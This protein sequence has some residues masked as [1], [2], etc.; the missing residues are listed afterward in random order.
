[1][2][3]KAVKEHWHILPVYLILLSLGIFLVFKLPQIVLIVPVVLAIPLVLV[4]KDAWKTISKYWVS[5]V[6]IAI[7]LL[8][9]YVRLQD[10]GW[11]YLRNIDSYMFYR[12]MDYIVQNGGIMP[13][14]DPLIL[15][16][17]GGTIR[18]ELFPFQYLGAYT[19]M[20]TRL[21][22][23]DLQLIQYLIYFP[24]LVASLAA[25]PMY[26]IG[27]ML[28]DKKAGILAA[29]FIVLDFTNVSRSLGGDPD[30]DAIVILV[31]LIVMVLFLFTYKYIN[32]HG[33]N[34]K[35]LV[36]S[37]ITGVAMGLWAHT[38]EGYWYVLW[39][40]TAM[41]ALKIV[42][43]ALQHRRIG[44]IIKE[45]R[46]LLTSYIIIIALLLLITYPAYGTGKITDFLGP[47]KFSQLKSEEGI[48]FPN[49]YVSVAELQGGDVKGVIQRTSAI[50]FGNAPLMIFISPLLL[51][52]YALIYLTYSFYKKRQHLDTFILL[53][54]WFLGPFLATIV[55]VRFST[56]FSAPLAIGSAIFLAKIINMTA[57]KEKFED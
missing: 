5:I 7:V 23:P 54:V 24:A 19:F 28:Y 57:N 18:Q 16:P 55:A 48:E 10:Y 42:I 21:F 50:D 36:Y 35:S 3:L 39:L 46:P 41:I 8:A 2:L 53:L 15:A 49:V 37:G 56:L 32:K 13:A 44:L 52:I 20:F 31:P 12:H 45:A 34:K 22:F 27:K 17:D 1:M 40:V 9:F 30:T 14:H 11:P 26:Y 4:R 29:L 33:L 51:M 47:F 25:I 43:Y 38:W 6:I